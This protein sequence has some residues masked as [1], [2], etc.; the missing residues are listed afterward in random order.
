[1]KAF[2]SCLTGFSFFVIFS[3]ACD[4]I[5]FKTGLFIY[6]DDIGENESY[7]GHGFVA[8]N[9]ALS[10]F[11][12]NLVNNFLHKETMSSKEKFGYSF[13]IAF[14]LLFSIIFIWISYLCIKYGAGEN[15]RILLF[16]VQFFLFISPVFTLPKIMNYIEDKYPNI[17][18]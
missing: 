1:M 7:L 16:Y 12:G 8:L 6:L 14:Y 15:L 10:F 5:S 4:V 13:C 2:I 18:D 9:L 3:I 17:F 11:L